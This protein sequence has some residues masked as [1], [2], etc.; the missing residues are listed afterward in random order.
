MS[1][2]WICPR[3]GRALAPWMPECPCWQTKTSVST[4]Y[5][6]STNTGMCT[7]VCNHKTEL[8]YCKFTACIRDDPDY[9]RGNNA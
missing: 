9:G 2:G 1:E 6:Y 3:C 8:G 5:T 4:N 7:R